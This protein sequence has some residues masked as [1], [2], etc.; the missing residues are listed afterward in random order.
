MNTKP[1][2]I[3][4]FSKP[5]PIIAQR[6]RERPILY[7]D[8]KAYRRSRLF[9]NRIHYTQTIIWFF[10]PRLSVNLPTLVRLLNR[11]FRFCTKSFFCPSIDKSFRFPIIGRQVPL[12]VRL[13]MSIKHNFDFYC[14][15]VFHQIDFNRFNNAFNK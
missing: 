1:R 2:K 3:G 7:N 14:K 5:Q 11:P 8:R 12:I 4:I 10:L 6:T 15:R 13:N 9:F